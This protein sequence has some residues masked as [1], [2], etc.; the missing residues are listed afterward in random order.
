MGNALAVFA[1][2][3]WRGA[4]FTVANATQHGLPRKFGINLFVGSVHCRT[5]DD[6]DPEQNR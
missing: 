4:V 1:E 2:R 6:N 3:L 5:G